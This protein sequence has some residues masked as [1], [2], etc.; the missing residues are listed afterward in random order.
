MSS[1][2]S[3]KLDALTVSIQE[4]KDEGRLLKLTKKTRSKRPTED[5]VKMYFFEGVVQ[6]FIIVVGVVVCVFV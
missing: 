2:I 6:R 4:S 5:R 1:E 3:D